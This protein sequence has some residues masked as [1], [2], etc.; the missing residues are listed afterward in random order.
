ML[1]IGQGMRKILMHQGHSSIHTCVEKENA[2]FPFFSIHQQ[3]DDEEKMK[4]K[5][6]ITND[7]L[8]TCIDFS[9]DV[10]SHVL[11]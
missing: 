8:S 2:L 4:G 6:T 5:S 9:S 1:T 11:R 3:D 7:Y 10:L